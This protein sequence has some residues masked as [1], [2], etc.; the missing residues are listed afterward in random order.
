M[1]ETQLTELVRRLV[2]RGR[3]IAAAPGWRTRSGLGAFVALGGIALR[4]VERLSTA[5]VTVTAKCIA[6]L[7]A[8]EVLKEEAHSRCTVETVVDRIVVCVLVVLPLVR[9]VAHHLLVGLQCRT[10]AGTRGD[11]FALEPVPCR[12]GLGSSREHKPQSHQ[13][14]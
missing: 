11:K 8:A 12:D 1:T 6:A 14:E 3:R 10:A 13:K 4:V 9:T 2:N 7:H 5:L